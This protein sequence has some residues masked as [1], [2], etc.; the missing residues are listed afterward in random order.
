MSFHHGKDKATSKKRI[1][2]QL[3]VLKYEENLVTEAGGS[4]IQKKDLVSVR[5]CVGAN[6]SKFTK[7]DAC[8]LLRQGFVVPSAVQ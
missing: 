2:K 4:F 8:T 3:K 5:A 1:K 6:K 7:V